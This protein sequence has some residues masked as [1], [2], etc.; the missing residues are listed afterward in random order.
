MGKGLHDVM[1]VVLAARNPRSCYARC[2][3]HWKSNLFSI[4]ALICGDGF[5]PT[6]YS[7][8][9]FLDEF[10]DGCF[11]FEANLL[12]RVSSSLR[13]FAPLLAVA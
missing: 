7:N 13:C 12:F 11:G 6:S 4:A 3:D 9:G 5:C 1:G 10:L 8:V 2:L